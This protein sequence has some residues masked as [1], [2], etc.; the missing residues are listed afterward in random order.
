MDTLWLASRTVAII[1]GAIFLY[2]FLTYTFD[3]F[4]QNSLFLQMVLILA[5]LKLFKKAKSNIMKVGLI[6]LSIISVIPSIYISVNYVDVAYR[7]GIPTQLEFVF[8]IITI[9]SI[10]MLTW[11][12]VGKVLTLVSLAFI[13]YSYFGNYIPGMW[14]HGGYPLNMLIGYLYM[15]R[16]GLW[17]TP[18]SIAATYVI[19]FN[20]MGSLLHRIKTTKLIID[21][22]SPI[23]KVKGGPGIVS[24]LSNM[25]LGMVSGS[26]PENAALTG[27]TFQPLLKSYG[28]TPEKSAAIIAAGAAGALIMPPV[29]GAAAF[30]MADLLGISYRDIVIAAFLPGFLYFLSLIIHV[31]LDSSLLLARGSLKGSATVSRTNNLNLIKEY[32]HTLIPLF[33]VTYFI[34]LGYSPTRAAMYAIISTILVSFIRKGTRLSLRDFIEAVHEAF[35]RVVML[36]VAISA[37][38]MIYSSV[39]MTGLGLK[40]SLTIESLSAGNLILALILIMFSCIILGM[41]LPATVAYLI[42]AITIASAVVKLGIPPIAAHMFIF[43]FAT[44]STIT[45]P[46]ALALYTACAIFNSDIMKSGY[47]A[48]KIALPAF[49]V[50]FIFTIRPSLLALGTPL[51]AAAS[52][53]L[54]LLGLIS[55]TVAITGYFMRSIS[56]PERILYG[57]AGILLAYPEITYLTDVVGL[58]ILSVATIINT[59]LRK[60][61][62]IK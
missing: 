41:G 26:A 14:G 1:Y 13:L 28:F 9:V 59:V 47:H 53:I 36:G 25:F 3:P 24:V 20:I 62:L 39:M 60:R 11:I 12:Y 51:E 29:M 32:G 16:E 15:T 7:A 37:A 49:I 31:Y 46:V 17:S 54:G 43:Y 2:S 30:L 34:L 6:P 42:V 57:L 33:V 40:L 45:P 58:S 18:M 10:L 22:L 19:A 52:F 50:P 5:F 61:K 44:F 8:G 23:S 27:T 35:D 21:G 48:I 4:L 38:C 56:I 55:I